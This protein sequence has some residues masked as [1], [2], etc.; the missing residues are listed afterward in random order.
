[1]NEDKLKEKFS[2][3]GRITDIQLKFTRDGKFR[4]FVFI[5][6]ETLDEANNAIGALHKSYIGT[7]QIQVET[8]AGLGKVAIYIT[9]PPNSITYIF[10]LYI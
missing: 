3:F 2:E 9:A 1:M 4:K 6:F 5:G 10:Y 7:N 8:C